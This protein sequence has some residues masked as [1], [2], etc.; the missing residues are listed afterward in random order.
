MSCWSRE[1]ATTT[2][3][4]RTAG[5]TPPATPVKT[6]AFTWK[7]GDQTRRGRRCRHLSPPGKDEHRVSAPQRP[8]VA[9]AHTQLGR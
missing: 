5:S 8:F 4:T 6:R 7:V 3:P 9:M 1:E 2:S